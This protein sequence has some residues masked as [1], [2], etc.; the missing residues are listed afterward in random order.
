[1]LKTVAELVEFRDDITG[2]HIERTQ[3]YLYVLVK[4]L[5]E[6]GVYA[7]EISQWDINLLLLSSQLHDVGKIAVKDSLLL[8][9]GPL[10]KE[11]FEEIKKHTTIGGEI[12]KKIAAS[13]NESAFLQHAEIFAL[14]HHERWD[15][16]GYPARLKGEEIPLQGRLMA[17]VDVYDALTNDRPYKKAILHEEALEII[18]GEIGTRFD[19]SVASIFLKH[20]KE[21]KEASLAEGFFSGMP[22]KEESALDLQLTLSKTLEEIKDYRDGVSPNSP[23]VDKISRYIMVLVNALLRHGKYKEVVSSWEMELFLLSAKLH[24]VGKIIVHDDILHQTR[25]LTETEFEKIK[26]HTGYGVQIIKKVG[27]DT[28]ENDFEEHAK[29]L[30]GSHHE[31]WDGTGYPMGLKGEAIPL[32][33]RLMAIIDVYDALTSDRPYKRAFPHEEAVAA[34][35]AGSETRFDP[36]LVSLFL[37]HAEEFHAILA[38]MQ[39]SL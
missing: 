35:K 4:S 37:D 3:G 24:D 31:K 23:H 29:A 7:E 26:E 10:T 28:A 11:E 27:D 20:E 9:P 32:Q 8:K 39:E 16:I 22:Q 17:I 21:I 1:V 36:L 30:A 25:S 34:I 13:T 18:K 5:L 12:I 15:G 14:C 33:G 19:P 2:S 6:H 38:A